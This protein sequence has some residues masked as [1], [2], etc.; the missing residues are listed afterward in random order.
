V[1]RDGARDLELRDV[2]SG[3]VREDFSLATAR[4]IAY[5][6]DE[7]SRNLDKLLTH[8]S[9]DAEVVTPDGVYRGRDAI[10]GVYRKSFTDY[11]RLSVDV[12]ASFVGRG[13]HCY[14]Y[15]AVLSDETKNDWLIEGIN[16]MKLEGGLISSLRS[17]E[18]APRRMSAEGQSR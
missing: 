4:I 17:F 18:D 13:A 10:A 14:E 1:T 9:S 8:F 11:P 15:R 3:A 16:L 12:T 7:C 5:F 6:A 2:W